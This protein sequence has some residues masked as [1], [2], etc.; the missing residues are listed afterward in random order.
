MYITIQI[1]KNC[2]LYN[3]RISLKNFKLLVSIELNA[4]H[5]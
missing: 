4:A 2:Y 5:P 3:L 1:K